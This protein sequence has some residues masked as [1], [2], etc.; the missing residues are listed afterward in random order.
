MLR[1]VWR[2]SV[3]VVG[4]ETLRVRAGFSWGMIMGEEGNI[5]G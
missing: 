1:K 2:R 3:L 4:L 5:Y